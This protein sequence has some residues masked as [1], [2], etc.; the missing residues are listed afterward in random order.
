MVILSTIASPSYFQLCF[1]SSIIETVYDSFRC[2]YRL[3]SK[4]LQVVEICFVMILFVR[5]MG[6]FEV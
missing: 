1:E 4:F 6:T 3:A 2:E 5:V